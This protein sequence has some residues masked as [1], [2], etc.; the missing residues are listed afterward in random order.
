MFD[1]QEMMK[2]KSNSDNF[3]FVKEVINLDN[4][5]KCKEIMKK[6]VTEILNDSISKKNVV[7]K[8]IELLDGFEPWNFD[9]LLVT[10]C[11]FALK[12]ILEEPISKKE[13][14]YFDNCFHNRLTY[15]LKNKIQF[16]KSGDVHNE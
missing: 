7:V 6:L 4:V 9:E 12:H 2:R 3:Q 8:V 16:I 5:I 10:D 1:H 14:I 13:W 11:Y 15:D